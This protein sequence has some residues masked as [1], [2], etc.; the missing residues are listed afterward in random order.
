MGYDK[1]LLGFRGTRLTI[2]MCVG[3]N[4][5][6]PP[7]K[8]GT[9]VLPWKLGMGRNSLRFKGHKSHNGDLGR[10]GHWPFPY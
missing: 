1:D 5:N 9:Q 4:K 3:G 10:M 6:P 8:L 7:K 2:R